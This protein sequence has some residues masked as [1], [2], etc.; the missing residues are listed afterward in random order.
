[1]AC[2][3]AVFLRRHG[4]RLAA[5]VLVWF[6]ALVIFPSAA[7]ARSAAAANP[8]GAESTRPRIGLVLSGGGARGYAHIGVLKMLERLRI[9]VDVITGTSI[10][11]VVGGLYA[12]G[13]RADALEQ[14]LSQVDLSDIA[15]DRNER[16]KLPQSLREDDFQYPIGLSAGYGDGKLKLP[17][18]LVQ[19]NRLLALLK[20]WT[21][22]WPDNIDFARLP[23]PFK[24]MATDL[25][26]GNP[27]ILDHG[28]LPLA[29][30]ARCGTSICSSA[31][32]SDR[33]ARV[34]F[35]AGVPDGG[36]ARVQGSA[37]L[38]RLDAA[39]ERVA[40]GPAAGST[41]IGTR[42]MRFAAAGSNPKKPS[43]SVA[44]CSRSLS[45]QIM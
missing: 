16:A 23:I 7:Y 21:A 12:S 10:G 27:V 40:A 26:T 8:E 30:R 22:R 9:P 18:G 32:C 36:T 35:P 28:S 17:A 3:T 20:N 5:A 42:S 15:F 6:A 29:I 34:V 11:A 33:R 31:A 45:T 14:Q 13:L 1:M 19:G 41:S 2:Q 44:T 43:T 38:H 39:H 37:Q 4:S 24:A 25:A